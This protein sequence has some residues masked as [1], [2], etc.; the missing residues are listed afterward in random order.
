MGLKL[1]HGN[2]VPGPTTAP[3]GDGAGYIPSQSFFLQT[4]L[5]GTSVSVKGTALTRGM[6]IREMTHDPGPL[7]QEE[8]AM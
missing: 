1:V 8:L 5:E 7:F 3:P 4:P 6:D 2:Q